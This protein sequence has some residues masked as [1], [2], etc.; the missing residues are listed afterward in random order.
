[1]IHGHKS[2]DVGQV[3]GFA[4][5]DVWLV[6]GYFYINPS[7]PPNF[8]DSSVILHFD[9]QQWNEIPIQRT[10]GLTSIWGDQSNQ[11]IAGGKHGALLRYVNGIW[12][13]TY[14]DKRLTFLDFTGIDNSIYA[15]AYIAAPETEGNIGK[16]FIL[17][18]QDTNFIIIDSITTIND[19]ANPKFG[20]YAIQTI[21]KKL[22]STGSGVFESLDGITWKK[23]L[24][25]YP[26]NIFG[27]FGT[28][29]NNIFACGS[30]NTL[31]HWN[32]TDWVSLEIPG[33]PS[34]PLYGVWCDDNEVF[35]IG[36]DGHRS[37]VIH[38]K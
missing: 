18:Q 35:V 25:T 32:G 33:D 22:Y 14:I 38:G 28:N 29:G 16:A 20:E 34:L 36:E 1:M 27:I 24:E 26:N 13:S 30:G 11:L 9:G 10:E 21:G 19:W 23:C 12:Q 15:L 4:S 17:K 8:L 5:N 3:F 37:Y 6:G 7:P 31:Y 2:I